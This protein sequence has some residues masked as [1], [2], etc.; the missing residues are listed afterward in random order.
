MSFNLKV[1][2]VWQTPASIWA[3]VSGTWQQ[4]NTAWIKV[5]GTWQQVYTSLAATADK[6]G[7]TGGDSGFAAC[8]DP[9]STDLV[10]V[11]PVGGTPPYTYAWA[12]V[13]P[14]ATHG[15]YQ[16][17]SPTLNATT[18]NDVNNQ[19]C[20]PAASPT[21]VWRCTVTDDN[22]NEATVDVNVTLTWTNLS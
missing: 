5:A 8:G 3:K 7:V 4:I 2:G 14:I 18:F 15:P 21:E 6:A 16:A 17:A 13:G 22:A 11:T 1:G 20:D 10:T 9:G 12:R 19:V